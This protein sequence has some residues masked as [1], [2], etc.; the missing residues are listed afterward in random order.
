MTYRTSAV[1]QIEKERNR[2]S[3]RLEQLNDVVAAVTEA[4]SARRG[5]ISASYRLGITTT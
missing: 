5:K 2:L 1:K 4:G 3:P